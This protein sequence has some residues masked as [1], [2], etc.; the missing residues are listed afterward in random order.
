MWNS[1]YDN[2]QNYQYVLDNTVGSTEYAYYNAAAKV[3]KAY[4]YEL[5]VNTYNDVPYSEAFKGTNKLQPKYDK[6][7]DIYRDLAI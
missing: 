6:A 1:T 4:N 2:L 7:E 5:L 3:M